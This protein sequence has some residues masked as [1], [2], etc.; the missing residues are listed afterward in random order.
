MNT[1][2]PRTVVTQKICYHLHVVGDNGKDYLAWE[3]D[4][5][6]NLRWYCTPD[7]PARG[8]DDPY[9]ALQWREFISV[10]VIVTEY[11]PSIKINVRIK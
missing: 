4:K 7:S 2:A 9:P 1:S 5:G 3:S 10:P 8:N 6:N 11:N